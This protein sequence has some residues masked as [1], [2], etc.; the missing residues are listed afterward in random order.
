L[1]NTIAIN[2]AASITHDNGFHIKPRNLRTLFSCTTEVNTSQESQHIIL[3]QTV[4]SRKNFLKK[5][6]I[7]REKKINPLKKKERPRFNIRDSEKAINI[8]AS[9]KT[10]IAHAQ[11]QHETVTIKWKCEVL[12]MTKFWNTDGS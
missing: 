4:F 5:I 12:L 8:C 9:T 11:H 3:M 2:A 6:Q 10:I 1:A 7:E